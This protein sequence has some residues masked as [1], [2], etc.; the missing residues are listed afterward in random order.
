VKTSYPIDE[1]IIRSIW[2]SKNPLPKTAKDFSAFGK[3]AAIRQA[4][5]RLAKSGKLKRIRRGFYER[6]RSHPIIGQST[7]SSM[8]VARVIM[9]SRHAPWQ[10]SGSSAANLLGLS[11]Q[12]PGQLVIKTTASIPPVKLGNSLIRFQRVAP[13]SLIGAGTEAGTVI[14][15]VRYL[16]P[17][18]IEPAQKERLRRSLKPNTKRD[19]RKLTQALPQWMQPIVKEISAAS[20]TP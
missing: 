11:E 4:L 12:V 17:V 14:Q 13:S 3:P 15:A 2:S 7:S 5:A 8:D 20:K 19:L 1:K 9:E 16:G 6:P 10:V 18:G